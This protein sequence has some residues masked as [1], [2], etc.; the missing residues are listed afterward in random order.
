M[1]AGGSWG[2][3]Q[4][5]GPLPKPGF[6]FMMWWMRNVCSPTPVSPGGGGTQSPAQWGQALPVID[7]IP[8]VSPHHL[9][10]G[11][12]GDEGCGDIAGGQGGLGASIPGAAGTN[13]AT[14]THLQSWESH[15]R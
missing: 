6:H 4:P 12:S 15:L 1:G 5:A 14:D 2:R 7:V 3:A 9:G 8:L 11:A 10:A 13:P